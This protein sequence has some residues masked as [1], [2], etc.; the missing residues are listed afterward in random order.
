MKNFLYKLFKWLIVYPLVI[1]LVIAAYQ[2]VTTPDV[3]SYVYLSCEEESGIYSL[4]YGDWRQKSSI[5]KI[6]RDENGL[7][8][9]RRSE[10]LRWPNIVM[11]LEAQKAF[12]VLREA[13]E[14]SMGMFKRVPF[15]L[16]ELN[17]SIEMGN[18]N[19]QSY[20][21]ILGFNGETRE[22]PSIYELVTTEIHLRRKELT[23]EELER[24]KEE[25]RMSERDYELSKELAKGGVDIRNDRLKTET[26]AEGVCK[27]IEEDDYLSLRELVKAKFLAVNSLY[28]AHQN[29]LEEEARAKKLEREKKLKDSLQI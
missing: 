16:D 28:E 22:I 10:G 15:S 3:E 19:T 20:L 14:N 6:A 26:I 8:I 5:L 11:D 18:P 2:T 7:G 23:F 13:S 4:S 17:D 1:I 27:V 25:F 12:E 9:V 21:F 24:S 29:S